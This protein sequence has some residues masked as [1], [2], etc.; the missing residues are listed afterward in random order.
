MIGVSRL[1]NGVTWST[2]RCDASPRLHD[3]KL[4]VLNVGYPLARVGPDQVGGAEQIVS[5]L[6]R[7][8]VQAGHTSFVVAI[9]GSHVAG[10]LVPI[11]QPNAPFDARAIALAQQN[12]SAA[13]VRTIRTQKIDVVHMHGVD[14]HAYLPPDGTAVLATLHLPPSWYPQEAFSPQRPRTWLNCVSRSQHDSIGSNLRLLAPILNG[15]EIETAPPPRHKRN[16]ILVLGR[17][18]PEKGIHIALDVAAMAR[19]PLILA[20]N[21]FPYREHQDYFDTMVKP[22]LGFSRRYV[23]PVGGERKRSLL[24]AARCLLVTSLVPETSSLVALEALAAGTPVVAFGKGA[25]PEVIDHGRTGFLA[26]NTR[27]LVDGIR[28]AGEINPEHCRSV[29]RE[30]FALSTMLERYLALYRALADGRLPEA[31]LSAA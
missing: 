3:V 25:L 21:V 8:L 4:S 14:F 9:E 30:R 2:S 16:F 10:T 19:V 13:I 7:G 28:A 17:V 24:A 1:R 6:D 22:R 23:G 11:P 31:V 26:S 18:C 20:G 27:E 29:A 12:C 15:T 5:A